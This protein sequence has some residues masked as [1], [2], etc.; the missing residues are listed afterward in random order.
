MKLLELMRWL[1]IQGVIENDTSILL[2]SNWVDV[3]LLLEVGN[4]EV[5]AFW[6]NTT[7]STLDLLIF[8]L[9]CL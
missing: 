4:S 3:V 8:F 2:L 5:K 7:S 6:G 9:L 1:R